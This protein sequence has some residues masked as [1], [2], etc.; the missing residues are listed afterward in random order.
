M[1][2]V[3]VIIMVLV[4]NGW[5]DDDVGGDDSDG[6]EGDRDD[7]YTPCLSRPLYQRGIWCK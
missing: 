5:I 7:G 6:D 3:M 4:M 1:V 2:V